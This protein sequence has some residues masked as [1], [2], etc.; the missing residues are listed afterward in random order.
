ML[1][2]EN[3]REYGAD[4]DE[5]LARCMGNEAF[6]LKMVAMGIADERFGSLKKALE[7]KDLDEAF[8]QAHALKGVVGNLALTPIAGPIGEMTALLRKREDA[9]YLPIYERMKEARDAL[10]RLGEDGERIDGRE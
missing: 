6:Y 9:D 10:A 3:L 8:E 4:V 7:E 1:T 2:I 5:G